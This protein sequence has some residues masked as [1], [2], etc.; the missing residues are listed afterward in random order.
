MKFI[1]GKKVGMTQVWRGEKVLAVTQVMAGPCTVVQIKDE[2]KDGYRAIQLGFDLK[3]EK[4]TRKPQKGHNKGLPNHRY[5]K[6]FRLDSKE[7]LDIKRG[8]TVDVT[9]FSSGDN[10][11]VSGT[12]KGKGFQGVVKRWG[13]HGQDSTHGHKDQERMSGSIGAGGVQHVFKGRKMGGRMGGDKI[14]ITNLEIIEVDKDNNSLLIKGA[15]PGPRNGLLLIYGPGELTIAQKEE[16][17]EANEKV[18]EQAVDSADVEE[19]KE[20]ATEEQPLEVNEENK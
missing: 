15:V 3:K 4:N 20:Q 17:I 5:L 13:F 2:A 10:I 7:T 9:T 6:E 1:I 11:K 16:K 12:S 14:T 8:D 19:K 18:E